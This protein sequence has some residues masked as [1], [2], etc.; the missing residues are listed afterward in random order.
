M[1]KSNDNC[2]IS[3]SLICHDIYP[4]EAEDGFVGCKLPSAL[5]DRVP[6]IK[7]MFA[8]EERKNELG[9][10]ARPSYIMAKTRIIV[11]TRPFFLINIEHKSIKGLC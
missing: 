7:Q 3:P 9:D 4:A 6:I 5:E 8:L 2:G 10:T 1:S 11:T